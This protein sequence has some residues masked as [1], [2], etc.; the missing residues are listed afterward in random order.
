MISLTNVP[1]LAWMTRLACR[2]DL[3]GRGSVALLNHHIAD[4]K[5]CFAVDLG[6]REIQM[7]VLAG[8]V[9]A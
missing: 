8:N 3:P 9:M 6:F 1:A 4:S 2:L 5:L 7:E